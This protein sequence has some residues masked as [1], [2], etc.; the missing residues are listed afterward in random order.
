[1]KHK[2]KA[3]KV[4]A[5]DCGCG[6][7]GACGVATDAI[8]AEERAQIPEDDFAGPHRSFP[9]RNQQDV[10]GAARLIGH[11]EDPDAVKAKIRAIAKRK[12]L[13][14]PTSWTDDHDPD[15]NPAPVDPRPLCADPDERKII[16]AEN[17][18]EAAPGVEL[19]AQEDSQAENGTQS[20]R[21][22]NAGAE[23][24]PGEGRLQNEVRVDCVACTDAVNAKPRVTE[25]GKNGVLCRVRQ[26]ITKADMVNRN[27]RLYPRAV[28]QDAI[29]RARDRVKVG[30][31]L[32]EL[33]HPAVVQV[34]DNGG[35]GDRFVDNPENKTG[36]ITAISD[37]QPDGSVWM[38]REILDT[39][40][41]RLIA[42]ALRRGDGRVSVRWMM[43]EIESRADG[44]DIPRS[45]DL[46][47]VDDVDSPATPGAG[48]ILAMSDSALHVEYE[49]YDPSPEGPEGLGD[50]FQG[51][52]RNTVNPHPGNAPDDA[53]TM[54]AENDSA[55]ATAQGKVRTPMEKLMQAYRAFIAARNSGAAIDDIK[56]R[57]RAF[58]DATISAYHE[59]QDVREVVRA[60]KLAMDNEEANPRYHRSK[61]GPYVELG[62]ELGGDPLGGWGEDVREG[63]GKRGQR[64]DIA[65]KSKTEPKSYEEGELHVDKAEGAGYERTEDEKEKDR[66]RKRMKGEADEKADEKEAEVD[67]MCDEMEGDETCPMSKMD[68]E[69]KKMVRDLAKLEAR[70]GKPVEKTI[71]DAIE[72]VSALRA[73]QRMAADN[74]YAATRVIDRRDPANPIVTTG[75]M[76]R[77]D[78]A[79]FNALMAATDDWQRITAPNDL[80]VTNPD[81]AS[82]K[83]LRAY[84]RSKTAALVD[85]C[86]SDFEKK[87]KQ[88]GVFS[89]FALGDSAGDPI[90]VIGRQIQAV[91]GCDSYATAVSALPNQPTVMRWLLT[92]AFQ[93][94]RMLQFCQPIGPGQDAGEGMPGWENQQGLGRVFKVPYETY[95]DP[96]GWGFEYGSVD[97]GLLTPENQG[98]TEGTINIYWDTFN[99][100]WRTNATSA[101]IQGLKS[102]GNGPLN[103]AA[104]ARNLWHMT[105][106]KSRSID[107]AL[108][109]EMLDVALE[110]GAVAVTGETY[111]A[112]NNGLANQTVFPASGAVTVNLNPAKT[113]AA[114][115]VAG[116]DYSATYPNPNVASGGGTTPTC[117]VRLLSGTAVGQN[118]APYFGTNT[119]TPNPTVRPRATLT[120][121]SA[122]ADSTGTLNPIAVSVPA[123]QVLGVLGPDGLI[124]SFP[125]TTATYAIDYANGVLLFNSTSGVTG[126]A[127]KINVTVTLGYSYATNFDYF[128]I[129]P[130]IN[131]LATQAT[132]ETPAAFYNRLLAQFDF[133]ASIQASWPRFVAPD[134]ALMSVQV[135][136][137]ITEATAFYKLNSPKETELYPSEDFFATRNGID[138][139]RL[140]TPWWGQN[141][142]IVET[143]REST[144][145]AMDTPWEV[146]GP[147]VKFDGSGNF[148]A[149]EGYL[150]YESSAICTPQVKN[151]SGNI[152]NPVARA[153]YLLK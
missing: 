29:N 47:T 54:I 61:S 21:I 111:T 9:I 106:R 22:N 70:K 72:R 139:A 68:G 40:A 64:R 126:A 41:G 62:N 27:M 121:T 88:K 113:A 110:Y 144:K 130:G 53:V 13:T 104:M 38:D 26:V 76:A 43:R 31:M 16:A 118:A 82:V 102:I 45:M 123:A 46:I 92:Q 73:G 34:C 30:T 58:V 152:V 148:I 32:S 1:M 108:A 91:A 98:I 115:V 65:Q 52:A 14:L 101:T 96:S 35:C 59:G 109:N 103:L 99:P 105:A 90:A 87:A 44:V 129:T 7:G 75:R 18:H 135:S 55:R 122:G 67:E 107:T 8:S 93:D 25:G 114:A 36:R 85:Q 149:G 4:F 131:G 146:R 143:R 125:G 56:V 86:L 132:G 71:G 141:S 136:P 50:P 15:I 134:L 153:I 100:L 57:D 140:N 142:F 112:G 150:G 97:F 63:E 138:M 19:M 119:F 84:N 23:K 151:S 116:T 66:D 37:V 95:V 120:L 124:Y 39:P 147:A 137:Y 28:V 83:S 5:P 3:W 20:A 79:A 11:A 24:S 49:N 94:M 80:K 127:G 2:L 74:A 12:G 117:A 51:I 145:Y 42:S 77:P 17:K 10:E 69:G 33:E 81:K 78:E 6:C 48:K 60:Y 133:T 128:P 89:A